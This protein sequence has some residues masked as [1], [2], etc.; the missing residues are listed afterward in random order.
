M[1]LRR[2]VLL[3]ILAA[4]LRTHPMH[5]Q[6]YGLIDADVGAGVQSFSDLS[7]DRSAAA[8]FGGET[9]WNLS[10][11]LALESLV[12]YSST[13]RESPYLDEGHQLDL[14]AGVRM[15]GR[16]GKLGVYGALKPG[17]TSFSC[18]L[19]GPAE[20]QYGNC[21]RRTYFALQTGGALEYFIH[22][23]TFLRADISGI[24]VTDF[25]QVFFRSSAFND[26]YQGHVAQH[27]DVRL[28]VGHTFGSWRDADRAV[29]PP[30]R[31]DVLNSG[32]LYGLQIKGH[33]EGSTVV[34]ADSGI[35]MWLDWNRWAH[36][37]WDTAV[38]DF[39]RYDNLASY[40]DGGT[41]LLAVSGV[42][43][44]L[45]TKNIG[46]F[47]KVRPGV[48]LFSRTIDWVSATPTKSSW[49]FSKFPD[50][51]FD[52]GGV[53]EIYPSAHLLLRAEAGDNLLVYRHK[54]V[55]INGITTALQSQE[56]PSAMFL[57]GVGYRFGSRHSS[58]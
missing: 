11:S 15:G 36:F 20:T 39:P 54:S 9:A 12:S 57:F 33:G 30:A 31:P 29:D 45:R 50:L 41:A 16:I 56:Y 5:A 28:S 22:P 53:I 34:S 23:R 2:G 25:D 44:G 55:V 1:T 46:L 3:L 21:M 32:V 17:L 35:G 38:I 47:A 48:I 37:S 18:G 7:N 27:F 14:F 52:T 10:S 26:S 24:V 51:A 4:V 42:K 40:Q 6:Q 49:I 43:A 13:F 58:K 19:R 8:T